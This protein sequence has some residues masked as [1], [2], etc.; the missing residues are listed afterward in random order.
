MV[1]AQPI[2][3]PAC[4]GCW[5][6]PRV[7]THCACSRCCRA[8]WDKS[9]EHKQRLF[10]LL[11]PASHLL[12]ICKNDL[13]SPACTLI[14]E[15][16][17]CVQRWDKTLCP[18]AQLSPVS[19]DHIKNRWSFLWLFVKWGESWMH[20]WS[21]WQVKPTSVYNLWF[22]GRFVYYSSPCPDETLVCW[23]GG[24]FL[25]LNVEHTLKVE[26]LSPCRYMKS[27]TFVFM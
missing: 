15:C 20:E 3:Q 14:L 16:K 19:L 25:V 1:S 12:K 10:W 11:V 21:N 8:E 23:C 17:H 6:L 4:G 9:C 22:I 26:R 18:A 24:L 27:K 5:E 7:W 13:N 2:R